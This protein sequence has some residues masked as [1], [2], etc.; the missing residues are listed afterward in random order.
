ME[1]LLQD[2][3]YSFRTLLKNRGF[4]AVAILTLAL[5]I[6]ANTAIFSVINAVLLQPLPYED[7]ERL[8]IVWEDASFAGFPRNTPAPGNY[9]DW[10]AQNQVFEDM[11]AITNGE[12][13]LTGDGEPEKISAYRVTANF[14][15]LLGVKPLLGRNFLQEEDKPGANRVAIIS[16]GLWQRR[17]GGERET[18]GREIL[19]NGEKYTVAGVMPARF[20]FLESDIDI[21]VPVAFTQAELAN[22][23]GHY[24]KVVARIKKGVGLQQARADIEAIMQRI[25]RDYPEASRL[26]AV[27]LPLREELAGEVQ[28]PLIMLLV[29]VGFVLLIACANIANLLLSRAA[30]RRK[31]IAIRCALGAG[32][33]RIMRQLLTESLLLAAMGSLAGLLLTYWSFTFLRHLIPEG[34]NLSTSLSVDIRV[35]SFTLLLSLVTGALFGLAPALQASNIQLNEALKQG[36]RTGFGPGSSRLRNA[37]IVAEVGMALV[38]LIGAGLLIQ[39]FFQ[40]YNQYSVLQAENVLTLRTVLSQNR[41]DNHQKRVAFHDQVLEKVKAI[42]GVSSAGYTTTIPL[43]WKGGTSGFVVEGGQIEMD[44][45]Y[46]ANHRQVSTDYLKTIG[47]PLKEGRHFDKSDNAQSLPVAIINETMARQYWPNENALGKRF[48]IGDPDSESPWLTIIGIAGD[49]RQMGI[50]VPVKAEMYLLNQQTNYQTWFAPRDLTI[51]TSGDPM[52][53]VAAVRDVVHAVDPDQPISNIRTMDQILGK[54][55]MQRRVGM[56][57][58]TAFAV[59]ALLLASIGIYGL[60]SYFVVQHMSDI[61][62]RLALGAQPGDILRMILKKGMLLTSLGIAIGLFFSTAL[63]RLISSLLFGVSSIDP[64]T[65]A[66]VPIL[67]LTIAFLAC[68]IPAR[69][70]SRV[71][72]I[73]AL[74]CE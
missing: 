67:L 63:T 30:N 15:P 12:F 54:E 35:L 42:P 22:R 13:S 66:V 23:G 21:W 72:P 19:L 27:V 69:R 2:L 59:L 17:Y 7:P 33:L 74:K 11:A 57:L 39:S 64:I 41:Y 3:R 28:R 70:A 31:E 56:I 60:L 61:G 20:Q 37:L 18:I 32:R 45:S 1:V 46:D 16:Y 48:K 34:M 49:I 6:G 58:L 65:F 62:I 68:Y 73:V 24:L 25:A 29:A 36:G 43:E 8:V 14:F 26:D 50:D 10:K 52:S 71:D 9:A 38:L 53:I 55:T 5:G 4:A 51:R 40:L 44:L 47:I